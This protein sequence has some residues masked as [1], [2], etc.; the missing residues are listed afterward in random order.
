M[1]YGS[2]AHEMLMLA[3]GAN[4]DGNI[5]TDPVSPFD[6]ETLFAD[7]QGGDDLPN[8]E[9]DISSEVTIEDHLQNSAS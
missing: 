6:L 2:V 7:G 3:H 1:M 8:D 9:E 5:A 4:G